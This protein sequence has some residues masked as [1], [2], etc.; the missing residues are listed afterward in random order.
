MDASN[1][2]E[3]SVSRCLTSILDQCV[4][5]LLSPTFLTPFV[6]DTVESSLECSYH[7]R[8]TFLSHHTIVRRLQLIHAPN[9]R[10]TGL[11]SFMLSDEMTT[12]SVT[13]S[14]AHKRVF[15]QRSHAWNI[16][17]PRFR[18][19]F[20]DVSPLLHARFSSFFVLDCHGMDSAEVA[21]AAILRW[22]GRFSRASLDRSM[23]AVRARFFY[24]SSLL[25]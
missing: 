8:H 10:L 5:S 20:P 12:G 15:A 23:A 4:I 1:L 18:E 16:L 9:H 7:V 2:T 11:L 14:D 6:W 21:E 3:G 13:S 25:R 24:R 19:A 17:Q 22:L